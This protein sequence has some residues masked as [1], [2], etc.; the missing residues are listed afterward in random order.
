M[1]MDTILIWKFETHFYS[2]SSVLEKTRFILG[3]KKILTL[4]YKASL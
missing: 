3:C 2:Y 4:I 1:A